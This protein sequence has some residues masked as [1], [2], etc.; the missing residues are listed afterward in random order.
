MEQMPAEPQ[1][2]GQPIDRGRSRR[3]GELIATALL[4]PVVVCLMAVLG[5][6][7]L[8]VVGFSGTYSSPS[9]SARNSAAGCDRAAVERAGDLLILGAV[10][11]PVLAVIMSVVLA[12]VKRF[13]RRFAWCPA[14]LWPLLCVLLQ[15]LCL[16]WAQAL[17]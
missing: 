17:T 8:W 15:L 13:T 3:T 7:A 16:W 4:W 1:G 10:L 12:V 5:Y 9:C 11:L 6:F 2:F 14:Y